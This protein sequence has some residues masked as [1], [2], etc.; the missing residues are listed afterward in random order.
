[1]EDQAKV[2]VLTAV[3]RDVTSR[4]QGVDGSLGAAATVWLVHMAL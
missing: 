3:C 1:V 2:V 4:V